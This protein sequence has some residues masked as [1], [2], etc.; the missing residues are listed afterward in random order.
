MEL[1]SRRGY[2]RHRGISEATVRK[3]IAR[4]KIPVDA[5]RID[6]EAA[7]AAWAAWVPR[8][9]EAGALVSRRA[10]AVSRGVSEGAVRKAIA[11][12]KIPV[13][14]GGMI[15]PGAADA[16]WLLNRDG[17]QQSR[18]AEAIAARKPAS[19]GPAAEV[20]GE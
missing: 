14:D 9:R 18:L 5:G 10:Y 1:L 8:T 4:G 20:P 2:A 17:G 11:R 19:A 3:A 7:D 16:A 13:T 12:G 15:D 6:S